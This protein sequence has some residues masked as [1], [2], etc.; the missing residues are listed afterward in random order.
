M[1]NIILFSAVA[2]VFFAC[3]KSDNLPPGTKQINGVLHYDNVLGGLGMYFVT[4]TNSTFIFK[5]EFPNDVHDSLEFR[6]YLYSVG[7]NTSLRYT[8]TGVTGC[9]DGNQ[10]LC[11]FPVVQIV[12][13]TVR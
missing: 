7:V 5:D 13:F 8:E 12:Y 3:K 9:F 1:K 2:F 4:D 6:K 11:G 10:S